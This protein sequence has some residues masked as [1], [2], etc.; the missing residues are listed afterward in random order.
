MTAAI[1]AFR[2]GN[3]PHI[4]QVF[5]VGTATMMAAKGAIVPVAK[6]MTDAKEPFDPK[7]YL[8]TVAGYYTDTQ[9]QHAVVPVQQLDVDVLH[10][11]G[12]LQEGG[13]RSG[14]GAEDLEG[15]SAPRRKSSR[16]PGSSASTPPAGR[17]G[18]TSRTSAPGT[19]C[20]S[21]PRRTAW[22]GSTPSSS[23]NSPLHVRHVV[24]AGRHVE[25]GPL[26]LRRPHAT[27]ARPSSRAAS[28]RCSPSSTG[29]QAN[30]RTQRR[31]ST[32]RST[33]CPTTTTSRAR[34]RTRSSA[35][36]RCG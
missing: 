29:A 11:Q 33:S 17:P 3:A 13:P 9:G 20:R 36:R 7:A 16:P 32:G 1:A 31:S 24:D 10:Q 35:A 34:R 30:I 15:S 2:A 18:C 19:T 5:E 12:R 22:A 25:E 8:P 21:A 26:H 28:A 14:E 4:L 27:R 23:I 6:V